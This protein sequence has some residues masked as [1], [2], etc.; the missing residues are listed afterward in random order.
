[1]KKPGEYKVG[2]KKPPVGKRFAPGMSGNPRGRP[3]GSA[4][5]TG[6]DTV[7]LGVYLS[8]TVDLNRTR[9]VLAAREAEVAELHAKL[10]NVTLQWEAS[11]RQLV[12]TRSDRQKFMAEAERTRDLLAECLRLL[13]ATFTVVKP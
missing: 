4:V 7:P 5:V 9:E 3:R 11:E 1:M 8:S 12:A 6:G 10:K 13:A 2:Y